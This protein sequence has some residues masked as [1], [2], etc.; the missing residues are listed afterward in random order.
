MECVKT[1]VLR[2][3]ESL[4]LLDDDL[5]DHSNRESE[6][7][8]PEMPRMKCAPAP[9]TTLMGQ[10][11]DETEILLDGLLD[12]Q[13]Q[14]RP[15]ANYLE[16]VQGPLI[17]EWHRRDTLDWLYDIADAHRL[18]PQTYALSI[19]Y[20]DRFLSV[21]KVRIEQLQLIAAVCMSLAVKFRETDKYMRAE[22]L[23]AS[24]DGA[25]KAEFLLKL[26]PY[27][28]RRLEHRLYAVTPFDFLDLFLTNFRVLIGDC[29]LSSITSMASSLIE[30][31][32][33]HYD[34]ISYDSGTVAAAALL[35]A[36]QTV[37]GKR[38]QRLGKEEMKAY[39]RG[40]TEFLLCMER[41]QKVMCSNYQQRTAAGY[42]SPPLSTPTNIISG[43]QIFNSDGVL[44]PDGNVCQEGNQRHLSV[45]PSSTAFPYF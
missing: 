6:P 39:L 10:P 42:D 16:H 29:D 33:I 44:D 12:M 21:C 7:G 8:S 14:L 40:D 4:E 30:L 23:A 26:E 20:F 5:R 22:D 13:G 15:N 28:L 11:G 41:I 38:S 9:V 43:S 24:S 34:F 19:N 18:M 25:F 37:Q 27:V 2:C 35:L 1:T 32:L 3:E 17:K 31:A 36:I 45:S